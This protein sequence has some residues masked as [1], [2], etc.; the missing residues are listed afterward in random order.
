MSRNSWCVPSLRLNSVNYLVKRFAV[1]GFVAF[2]LVAGCSTLLQHLLKPETVARVR[3]QQAGYAVSEA[4]VFRAIDR[5][6]VLALVRLQTLGIPLQAKDEFGTTAYAYA[7]RGDHFES[8]QMLGKLGAAPEL[9]ADSLHS[10]LADAIRDDSI[11]TVA[12]LL[13]NG[14]SANVKIELGVSALLWAMENDRGEMVELLLEKGAD[15][16][17]HDL[18]KTPLVLAYELDDKD[19][20]LQFL[21]EGVDP[22][23]HAADGNLI[24]VAAIRDDRRWA[25]EALLD[26][27]VDTKLRGPNGDCMV[28][29]AFRDRRDDLFVSFIQ[30]GG[31]SG[32]R[33]RHGR[34]FLERASFEKDHEWM[35]LLLAQ[36][37]NPNAHSYAEDP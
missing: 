3:L 6:D 7:I 25:I 5:N 14:A 19:L 36:G 2:L 29:R 13:D 26:R 22:N 21:K 27:G 15:V 24:G 18:R 17:G 11:Q 9:T 23:Q 33:D 4:S 28:E 34:T 16:H 1:I 32:S 8:L 35:E 31:D 30:S 12:Y 10:P 20:F 37:V